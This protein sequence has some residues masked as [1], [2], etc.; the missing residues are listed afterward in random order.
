MPN[1]HAAIKDLRKSKKHAEK[2]ARMKTHSKSL[3][4]QIKDLIKEGKKAEALALAPK[5]QK[6]LS[7]AAKTHV[8]HKN[9]SGRVVASIHKALGAMK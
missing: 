8:F 1:K 5:V 3:V 7:K 4:R 9:K 6:I 2:N